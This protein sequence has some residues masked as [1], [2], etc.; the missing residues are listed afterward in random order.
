MDIELDQTLRLAD[1]DFFSVLTAFDEGVVIADKSGR[2]VFYNRTQSQID[3]LEPEYVIGKSVPEVY[4]LD[5]NS[6]MILRCI[7]S[8]QPILGELFF[9]RTCRGKLV[10]TVNSTF[11]LMEHGRVSGAICFIKDYNLLDKKIS[12]IPAC[13]PYEGLG[14][15]NGTR[16]N[17][18][19][20]IG[21]D[22]KFRQSV[23]EAR[24]TADSPSP[25]MLYGETGT[26]K[27]MFA[28][29]IHNHGPRH[30][31][32]FI[33]INCAA[34]PENLL[35][36]LL[37]GTSKGAFTG[38]VNKSGIL[39][40][41][42]GGTLFL[43]EVDSMPL[44]LQTKLLRFLQERKIRRVGGST[45]IKIDVK[46]ISSVSNNPQQA[47][48]DGQIRMDLFYRLAVV[49]I[50]IPPLRDLINGVE[51]LTRH[52]IY[53]YNLVLGKNVIGVSENVIDI[54]RRYHWPGN[55]RELEHLIEG[56]LN[57]IEAEDI[58]RVQHLPRHFLPPEF[59]ILT[60]KFTDPHLNGP[61]DVK[62]LPELNGAEINVPAIDEPQQNSMPQS[63]L[64][65]QKTR[66]KELINLALVE[67][68]G[69]V[70][71]AARKLNIS[72]QLLH[73]KMKKYSLRR[74]SFFHL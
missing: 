62:E 18:A 65:R 59:T 29:S 71:R 67:S 3:D 8:G 74:S 55:V 2:I 37:F 48:Q 44:N 58:I 10:N 1:I 39:E 47:L 40:Q 63:L 27:E 30:D 53:K 41:A 66:E 70:S 50:P 15:G 64:R 34:I 69:N 43:D 49:F 4:N 25:V 5:Q 52:F 36:G 31:S 38:A 51:A 13:S 57:V 20:I 35:E 6:S 11:P 68:A 33:G 61:S 17:F 21:D 28:Q 54:F 73:Y 9:Y 19:D 42:H 22:E 12:A 72:R 60:E 7:K 14:Y 46:I 24:L 56:T 45:D 16:F 32:R 26:G 23:K